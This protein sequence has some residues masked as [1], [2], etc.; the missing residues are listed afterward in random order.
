M[1]CVVSSAGL[2]SATER[3]GPADVPHNVAKAAPVL[4]AVKDKPTGGPCRAALA[5]RL[6]RTCDRQPSN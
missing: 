6:G 4:W 3:T 5:E 2:V 1:D